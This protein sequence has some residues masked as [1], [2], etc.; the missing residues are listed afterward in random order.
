M[1][2][3]GSVVKDYPV[4]VS[5]VIVIA[6]LVLGAVF[7]ST[8][9]CSLF[10]RHMVFLH[11]EAL[12]S[13]GESPVVL[14]GSAGVGGLIGSA[15]GFLAVVFIYHRGRL[16][17]GLSLGGAVLSVAAFAAYV[18]SSDNVLRFENY[19]FTGAFIALCGLTVGA[20]A[21]VITDHLTGS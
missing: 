5:A 16:T 18:L 21:G 19:V 1:E 11:G 3:A 14:Y 4:E 2:K 7:G 9:G 17:V 6:G 10:A 12:Q 13:C 15:L 20:M 8:L